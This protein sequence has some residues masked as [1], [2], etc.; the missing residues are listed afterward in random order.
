MSSIP[1]IDQ[2]LRSLRAQALKGSGSR[3]AAHETAEPPR[4][5]QATT[6]SAATHLAQ[7]IREIRPDD[8]Q[9]RR[10]AFRAFLEGGLVDL[11][12]AP[13]TT[14]AAFQRVVDRVHEAM[15]ASPDF[16]LAVE[17]VADTLLQ[18]A[19]EDARLTALAQAL[20]DKRAP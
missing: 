18:A 5:G 16:T 4:R 6:S 9:R 11:L 7:R 8:P 2:V 19:S 3:L 13:A 20:Y 15:S 1:P 12:G 14:D 10:R 17:R